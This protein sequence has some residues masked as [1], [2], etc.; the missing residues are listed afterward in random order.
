MKDQGSVRGADKR[1]SFDNYCA[2]SQQWSLPRRPVLQQRAAA[3]D[4]PFRN[5]GIH[6]LKARRAIIN[7]EPHEVDLAARRRYG[8][9]VFTRAIGAHLM[10]A[11]TQIDAEIRTW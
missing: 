6:Q 4:F 2:L 7:G 1:S 5:L 10:P 11:G 3:D 8:N 9:A